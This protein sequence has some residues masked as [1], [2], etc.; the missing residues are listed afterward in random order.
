VQRP[1]P[2]AEVATATEAGGAAPPVPA[3]FTLGPVQNPVR[4]TLH[5]SAALVCLGLAAGAL[6]LPPGVAGG[7][8]VV[9]AVLAASHAALF[10]VSALYH[11]VPWTA[12]WKRRVQRID[13]TM[14]YVKIAGTL[15]ALAWVALEGS[16]QV[17]LVGAAWG[18]AAAGAAQTLFYPALP[19]R[20]SMPLQ[21]FQASLAI[22]A[23][24]ALAASE[25]GGAQPWLL[26][27]PLCYGT[28][29]VVFLT[30]RPRLWPRVFSFHEL[31]HVLVVVGSAAT[32]LV[33]L[34]V[35]AGS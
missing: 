21:L 6:E 33:V 12:P 35:L 17:A 15:T 30:E 25:G 19:E 18:I 20:A 34:R 11:S 28:G 23:L 13:H 4:G 16:A 31:F 2:A 27:G 29:A 1:W 26:A 10:A 9:L 24:A 8:R 3:R 22:P 7:D 5:G 32:T 14:I